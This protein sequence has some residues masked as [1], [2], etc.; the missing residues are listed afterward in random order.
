MGGARG[1]HGEDKFFTKVSIAE[2]EEK[3]PFSIQSPA[4]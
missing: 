4:S 2:P 1:A 3:G